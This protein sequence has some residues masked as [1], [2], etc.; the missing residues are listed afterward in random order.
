[1]QGLYSYM[2]HASLWLVPTSAASHV[3]LP[4]LLD[5]TESFAMPS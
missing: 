1:M 3:G 2:Q 4:P 5:R